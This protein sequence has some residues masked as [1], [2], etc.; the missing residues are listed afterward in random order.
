MGDTRQGCSIALRL[1]DARRVGEKLFAA[2]EHG[3]SKTFHRQMTAHW[4]LEKHI[5]GA[6]HDVLKTLKPEEMLSFKL[7][8]S[9]RA[10]AITPPGRFVLIQEDDAPAGR[11]QNRSVQRKKVQDPRDQNW[12]IWTKHWAA[13]FSL[14]FGTPERLLSKA[15]PTEDS[16]K[17]FEK[18]VDGMSARYSRM[19]YG[20]RLAHL[21]R[22]QRVLDSIDRAVTRTISTT[23]ARCSGQPQNQQQKE[24]N[25]RILKQ[26]AQYIRH[27]H[28]PGHQPIPLMSSRPFAETLVQAV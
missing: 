8:W 17:P 21:E 16:S 18:L 28:V 2:E 10:V 13:G 9:S 19:S 4:R 27:L 12:N 5:E 22:A 25:L 26:L 15:D 3:H 23:R 24:H 7:F 1:T 11:R 14:D 6:Q 20:A